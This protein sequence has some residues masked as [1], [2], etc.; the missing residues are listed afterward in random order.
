MEQLILKPLNHRGHECIGIYFN[1]NNEIQAVLQNKLGA[2]WSS[3][4]VCWYISC[5]AE[6]YKLLISHLKDKAL[7][8][9]DELREYL[10]NREAK[11]SLSVSNNEPT[12]IKKT[13]EVVKK[14]PHKLSPLSEENKEALRLFEQQMV[15]KGFTKNTMR[16]YSSEFRQFLA[17]LGSNS[18]VTFSVPRLKDY[19]QYCHSVLNLTEST[20]HSKI[21]AIKF[22]YEQVLGREK[23]FWDIPRPKKPLIL[24]KVI[25]K[26]KIAELIN[27]I[28]N[29]KHKTIIMLTYACGLRVEEVVSIKI[30]NIDGKRQVLYIELGKNKKDRVLSLSPNMLIM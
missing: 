30:R 1:R 21:N 27:S 5:T 2:H 28:K 14:K 26:E 3:S 7:F 20:I 22:Y 29:L 17:L 15:L 9:V 12:T 8:N 10:L 11:N 24:P 16:T 23:F 18:A 13:K 4:Q 25:N 19:F 6:K